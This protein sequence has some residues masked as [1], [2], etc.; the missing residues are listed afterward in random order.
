MVAGCAEPT[1]ELAGAVPA[2]STLAGTM[3]DC[4]HA[5]MT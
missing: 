4:A 5:A 3:P 1:V 2:P